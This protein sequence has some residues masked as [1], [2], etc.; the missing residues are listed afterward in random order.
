MNDPPY[1][2]KAYF[3][4]K[5]TTRVGILHVSSKY[6]VSTN[7]P[8]NFGNMQDVNMLQRSVVDRWDQS[9]HILLIHPCPE[10]LYLRPRA[11]EM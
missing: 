11:S 2:L 7:D 10:T 5:H 1:S 8:Y 3:I 4:Y 9:D 6:R